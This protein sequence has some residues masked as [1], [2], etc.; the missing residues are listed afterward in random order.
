M[1]SEKSI[2]NSR[3][4]YVCGIWY[5]ELQRIYWYCKFLPTFPFVNIFWVQAIL[6]YRFLMYTDRPLLSEGLVPGELI[7]RVSKPVRD[8]QDPP[9]Q[10]HLLWSP[11][12]DLRTGEA[13][14]GLHCL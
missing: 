8:C 2:L 7:I 6:I 11:E 3:M 10:L 12:A 4:G 5:V 13:M 1:A 14:C 9:A